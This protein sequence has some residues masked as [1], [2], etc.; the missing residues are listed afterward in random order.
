MKIFLINPPRLMNL[1]SAAMK[2]SPSLGLALI[3]GALKEKK[4]TIKVIDAIA[5]APDQYTSFE[6]DIVLNGL[7]EIQIADMIDPD[8]DIIG[9]SLMFSGNWLHNKILLEVLGE[10]FPYAKIIAGGEHITA[11][12]KF[13]IENTN[14]LDVCIC[15]EGEETIVELIDGFEKQ[16]DL[17]NIKGIVYRDEENNVI[18]NPRR[19]RIKDIESIAWPAWEYFPLKK[20]KDNSIIYGVDRDVYSVPIMAT[21]GCPY[22]CTFCSSPMMWGTRYYMRTPKNVVD[23]INF[24]HIK[25]GIQN[26][27]FTI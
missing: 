11:A 13:C 10:K 14:H 5:E 6:K 2:P 27:D 17:S 19:L 16:S 7:N 18:E 26:F 15:G 22:S 12:A 24:L 8:V 1:M 21:R 20:Y 9:L 4:H 25:F 23:E 3:A